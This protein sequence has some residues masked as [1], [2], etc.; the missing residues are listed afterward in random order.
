VE[1][2]YTWQKIRHQAAIAG[3]VTDA[4]TTKGI[5]RAVVSI[6]DG[7][8]AFMK[9]LATKKKQ[10]GDKW[11][12]LAE[13][14]DRYRTSSDGHFHFIDLPNGTYTLSA[15]LPGSGSRF[16]DAEAQATVARDAQGKIAMAAADIALPPTSIKGKVTG[17]N[18]QPVLLAEVRV[19]G[20]GERAFS[21]KQGE[22]LVSGIEIGE[23]T[24]EIRAQGYQKASKAIQFNDDEIGAVKTLDFALAT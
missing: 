19:K 8:E 23:R 4:Q 1:R 21:D 9:W 24:V 16:S 17:K 10:F 14:P 22:Y 6:K 15:E 7:P 11:E 5:G 12:T 13:R 20:S 2:W 3:S 18:N